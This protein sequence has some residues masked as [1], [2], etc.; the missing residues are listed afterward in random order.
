MWK[1]HQAK[2]LW[3]SYQYW[4][5]FL[6]ILISRHKHW[7]LVCCIFFYSGLCLFWVWACVS[8][9]CS[10]VPGTMPSW[11]WALLAASTNTSS[12]VGKQAL[13]PPGNTSRHEVWGITT[14]QISLLLGKVLLLSTL[15]DQVGSF[16]LAFVLRGIG[17]I[18]CALLFDAIDCGVKSLQRVQYMMPL[19]YWIKDRG[20]RSALISGK[21]LLMKPPWHSWAFFLHVSG[22]RK[23]GVMGYAASLSALPVMLWWGW[24]K[25]HRTP[26]TGGEHHTRYTNNPLV[27]R[28][29]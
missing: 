7:Y 12:S 28:F 13:K 11:P 15:F 3:M 21:V 16:A 17:S 14:H 10:S 8:P 23:S 6:A 2:S 9:W 29:D 19:R 25:D 24:R 4:P 27:I 22:Q 1:V 20:I 18:C 26:K 5:I